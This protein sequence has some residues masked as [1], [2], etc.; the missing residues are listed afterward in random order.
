MYQRKIIHSDPGQ[1][2]IGTQWDCVNT[3]YIMW[4]KKFYKN[5][6]LTFK[7]LGKWSV[8]NTSQ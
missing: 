4:V 8:N 6:K 7:K 1:F 3:K 2:H 5:I